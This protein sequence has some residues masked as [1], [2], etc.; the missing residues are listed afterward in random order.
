MNT[1]NLKP[2]N[3]MSAAQHR[4]LSRKGGQVSG[5]ARRAKRERIEAAKAE[6]KAKSEVWQDELRMLH[7]IAGATKALNALRSRTGR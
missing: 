7:E 3:T 1:G 6:Q 2:F 4:E 5:A